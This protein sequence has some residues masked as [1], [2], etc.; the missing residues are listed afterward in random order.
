MPRRNHVMLELPLDRQTP[1]AQRYRR[2]LYYAAQ[3]A[4][5]MSCF[6]FSA[7]FLLILSAPR[8][9]W[10][11][12]MMFLVEAI[13]AFMSLKNQLLTVKAYK[14][15]NHPPKRL[16]LQGSDNLPRVDVLIT[17]CGEPLDI[18]LDTVRA[19]C[20]LDYP[21]SSYRVLVLDDG[22]SVALHD[23]ICSLH[24]QWSHLS[25]HTRGKQ[26]GQ[27]FA[28]SGNL[29]NALFT[30]QNEF[31]PEFCVV[32]DADSILMPDFLRATLPHLLQDPRV[33]LIST[34]QYF[35][36]LPHKDPLAQS[37][38][39]F[40]TRRNAELDLLGRAIDAGSG[41]VFRRK[42]IVNAGG[43]PTF[44]FSEDWQ[45]SLILHGL[46]HRIRQIQEVLQFGLVPTTL[47]GHI[48]QQNR[49]HIGHSQQILAMRPPA[50]RSIP[51]HLQWKIACGGLSILLGLVSCVLGFT[52]VPL[53]LVSGTLI[54][55]S[56][57]VL[58]YVQLVLGVFYIALM[59]VYEWLQAAHAGV[60]F[61]PFSHL[62]NSW[63]ASSHL[64]ATIQ[65]H[66]FSSK[67]KG[68]FV[69]GSTDNSKNISKSASSD[70]WH[71]VML[72]NICIFIATIVSMVSVIWS[73]TATAM[74]FIKIATT[75]AWPPMLHLC[76]LTIT[77]TWVPIA[78]LLNR[79]SYPDR[80]VLLGRDQSGI[81]YP[82]VV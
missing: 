72:F 21:H 76:Y 19:A 52:A 65:F 12:W 1:S 42:A 56:S 68:S 79:P 27:T 53:L 71:N 48:K 25:Y 22:A 11:V 14:A 37:R 40:Y 34:R 61:T 15:P 26:S 60:S 31:Q 33:V 81:F 7:R 10:H 82:T 39:H 32:V 28:K 69:T 3:A 9:A 35:Y 64:Y 2:S 24:T 47:R 50:N 62:E 29:N 74:P 67:P 51:R 8:E 45:L 63:L 16:R 13:F 66:F 38:A 57:P 73:A 4:V 44:S 23:A 17:C 20:V 43:Y 55:A 5:W 77:N 78:Y 70:S 6:Y 75:I 41:A 80:N 49:W 54:P 59:W 46:G 18:I 30:L 58:V 36:N